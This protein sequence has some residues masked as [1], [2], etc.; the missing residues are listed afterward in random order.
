M[1]SSCSQISYSDYNYPFKRLISTDKK[2]NLYITQKKL[3]HQHCVSM[4]HI[5]KN[6]LPQISSKHWNVYC[7]RV[8]LGPVIASVMQAAWGRDVSR[9]RGVDGHCSDW[10]AIAQ[11]INVWASS[12]REIRA[13]QRKMRKI[14]GGTL[15]SRPSRL[16]LA[17]CS[18]VVYFRAH[19]VA[20]TLIEKPTVISS[21]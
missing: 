12:L 4:T 5:P 6:C 21:L 14:Q 3:L 8:I 9:D 11:F 20:S 15:R 10:A 7:D 18:S 1:S 2:E 13:L 19:I 17:Y 16:L